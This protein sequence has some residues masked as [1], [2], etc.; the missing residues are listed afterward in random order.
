[1]TPN[2]PSHS[3]PETTLDEPVYQFQDYQGRP[4]LRYAVARR[5]RESCLGCHNKDTVNSP[6]LDWKV[7]DVHLE[8][9]FPGQ[10]IP[11]VDLRPAGDAGLHCVAT[12]LALVVARQVFRQ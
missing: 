2:P 12:P 9:L 8:L 1:M 4:V 10:G 6:K 11:S 7:C 5:L 3:N